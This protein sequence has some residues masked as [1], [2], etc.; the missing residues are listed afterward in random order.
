MVSFQQNIINR[1]VNINT[2]NAFATYTCFPQNIFYISY[3]R[4]QNK[5]TSAS[6]QQLV[7]L[8][9]PGRKFL[10]DFVC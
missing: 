10:A 8:H 3:T 7:Q 1:H 9:A 2:V 6:Q 4:S 5:H